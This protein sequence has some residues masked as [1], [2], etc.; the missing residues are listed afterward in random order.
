[1]KVKIE[2]E[3]G[4]TREQAEELLLKALT[5]HSHGDSHKDTFLDPAMQDLARHAVSEYEDIIQDLIRE[6]FDVIDEEYEV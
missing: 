5:S 3:K 2:L 6:V 4:E 1:M